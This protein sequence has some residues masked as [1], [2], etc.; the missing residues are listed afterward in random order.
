M[1]K[2]K[3][4]KVLSKIRGS[5]LAFLLA[6]TALIGNTSNIKAQTY[7][8]INLGNIAGTGAEIKLGYRR[9]Q[10]RVRITRLSRLR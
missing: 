3:F 6:F 9:S 7:Q 2:T 4:Y 8:P 10:R 1:S 5:T